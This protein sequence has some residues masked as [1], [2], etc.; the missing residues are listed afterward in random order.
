MGAPI[1]FSRLCLLE[2][3]PFSPH[4]EFLL[5][6]VSLLHLHL[7]LFAA[8]LEE[9]LISF[10]FSTTIAHTHTHTLTPRSDVTEGK[11]G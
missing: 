7:F 3:L 2:I 8:S 9:Y 10:G 11:G 4:V 6:G 5:K 1:F